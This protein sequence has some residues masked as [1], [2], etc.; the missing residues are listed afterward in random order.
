MKLI[1]SEDFFH[2]CGESRI[3]TISI[4]V[5]TVILFMDGISHDV[6]ELS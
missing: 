3:V 6:I 5:H 4:H 2:K 1:K